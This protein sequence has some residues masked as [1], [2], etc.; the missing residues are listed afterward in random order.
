MI[1]EAI[2]DN[3]K[4]KE[5]TTPQDLFEWRFR[6]GGTWIAPDV[7]YFLQTVVRC[8]DNESGKG[9]FMDVDVGIPDD[10]SAFSVENHVLVT[11]INGDAEPVLFRPK[12]GERY[13]CDDGE[14]FMSESVFRG[15]AAAYCNMQLSGMPF[16]T[17]SE[18]DIE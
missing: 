5:G 15:V 13:V 3:F 17:I 8:G 16:M 12:P 7:K 6:D 9:F 10:M 18:G 4:V 14:G 1:A 2:V 11:R